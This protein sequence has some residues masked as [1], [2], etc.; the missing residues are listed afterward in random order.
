MNVPNE[1][2]D[3]SMSVDIYH[4]P[5]YGH[6]IEMRTEDRVQRAIVTKL[7][8]WQAL[9]V[10]ATLSAVAKGFIEAAFIEH[11]CLRYGIQAEL[12]VSWEGEPDPF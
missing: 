8:S 9:A 5:G 11:L 12:P 6:R 4:H 10:P 2:L 3:W 7:G 1:K